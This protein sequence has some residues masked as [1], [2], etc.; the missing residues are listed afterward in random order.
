MQGESVVISSN[1]GGKNSW[2]TTDANACW[3]SNFNYK[4]CVCLQGVNRMGF[5]GLLIEGNQSSANS[6]HIEYCCPSWAEEGWYS[7]AWR[8][9]VCTRYY[10]INQLRGES[11]LKGVAHSLKATF[12]S[13]SERTIPP[14]LAYQEYA[15]Y[16]GKVTDQSARVGQC[17]WGGCWS[18]QLYTGRPPRWKIHTLYTE[19]SGQFTSELCKF[20]CKMN[21]YFTCWPFRSELKSLI[22]SPDRYTF[23]KAH[24]D[25]TV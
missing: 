9:P 3:P 22:I 13:S 7:C 2:S 11:A 19:V 5:H 25:L 17:V 4:R 10:L 20:R 15:I 14:K 16:V 18:P 8:L 23:K 21:L 6:V 12:A 24:I 1:Q